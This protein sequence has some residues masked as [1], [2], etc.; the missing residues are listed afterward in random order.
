MAPAAAGDSI[1]PRDVC[2]VGVARTPMGGFLGSL[3]SL[4]ATKLGSVAIASALKRANIDPSLVEEVFFG[5]V[6]SANLGQAPARQAALGAGIPNTVVCTTVNKVCASGMKATMLAAQ[7]IQLGTNDVVVAGGMESMSNVPKYLSEARKGS[8]LGHDSVVD[9]MLKD[10]LWDVYNDFGMGV[11]AELCAE[12]HNITREEQDNY[13]VQSF[14]RGIAAKDS[15]AFTWE[16]V[17]VEVSGGRG[18]PS[19]IIDTDEGLGKFD[20]AK[21]RKLRPSFKET[22]GS[23]TAGNASSISDGAAALVLVSGE[24][25]LKLGLEVIA[26]IT[27]Y[28]DA[29]QAPE[30][31]TTTPALAIP[32]AIKN[33]GLESSQIDYYEINEAFAVVAL[34]NQKLLGLNLE[35]VNVHG[36]AVSLGHP[37]GCSGA[38]ILATLL[39]VL[40]QKNGKYGVAGVCNGGGGA[41][42]LVLELV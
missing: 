38:R 35:K 23:V 29:A 31:F 4:P 40:R 12:Q 41:S 18:K 14:E 22:G 2:I 19:I 30:L 24:K 34:A 15:G 16:I 8:R 13:A 36:G 5:N 37:L 32:K 21:L 39:G 17:P 11:C 3:S 33:A 42:A 28:A 7:S 20:A 25:A 26:K 9:G 6:L 27:G 1:K 10:G